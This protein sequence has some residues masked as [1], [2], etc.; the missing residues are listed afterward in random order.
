MP[1]NLHYTFLLIAG[2]ALLVPGRLRRLAFVGLVPLGLGI[3][4]TTVRLG[5]D[6]T[7]LALRAAERS[8]PLRFLQINTGLVLLGTAV[9]A[10]A[11]AVS[12]VSR[13]RTGASWI[14][15][16]LVMGGAAPLVAGHLTLISYVGWLPVTVAALVIAA[17][18]IIFFQ[19][20]HLIPIGR[21]FPWLDQRVLERNPP[22]LIPAGGTS[23]DLIWVIGFFVSEVI[24]VV[25]PSLRAFVLAT[26]VAGTVGHVLMRR[27]GG[28]SPI[29][30]SVVAA[31]GIIPVYQFITTVT[32]QSA[33]LMG[34]LAEAPFSTAAAV[35]LVPWLA[36]TAWGLSGLWPLH[37]VVF[38]LIAP[39]SGVLLLRLGAHVVPEAMDHWAPVFM[40]IALLGIWH[41]AAS[42]RD[43]GARPRR[44]IEILTALAFLGAFAGGDGMTGAWWLLGSAALVPWLYYPFQNWLARTGLGG[45][46][47]LPV[48]WGALLVVTGG[49]A[50]QVTYTVLAA[51]GISVAIWVYHSPE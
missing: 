20:G 41:V 19:A 51:T 4:A 49:L 6:L 7:D 15:M 36:A 45:M 24:L 5:A 42:W 9:I 28:G 18:A 23:F 16:F 1:L 21:V 14:A 3:A 34:D 25:T 37:G 22:P 43:Q 32:G 27:L 26:V 50:T 35:R 31:L 33:P 38:P 30:L 10:V 39:L 40:P 17:G 13:E 2:G 8:A 11:G 46:P 47:W 29:P 12:L 44:L 48:A